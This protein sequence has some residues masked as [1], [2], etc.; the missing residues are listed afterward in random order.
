MTRD[1]PA[2]SLGL[3]YTRLLS[4]SI[5]NEVRFAYNKVGLTQD[6]TQ[7]LEDLI[8]GA[9]APTTKSGHADHQRQ[10]LRRHRCAACQLRQRAGD[11]EIL[12]L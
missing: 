3:G 11:E 2:R 10:R 1:V 4:T 6:A 9:L 5:V 12:R 8:P 7:P